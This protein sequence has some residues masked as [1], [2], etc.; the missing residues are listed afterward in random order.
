MIEWQRSGNEDKPKLF[1]RQ[2]TT[3]RALLLLAP[4]DI[5][6]N[7]CFDCSTDEEDQKVVAD[8]LKK[9]IF[10]AITLHFTI[11]RLTAFQMSFDQL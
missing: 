4:V 3:L 9:T 10:Y 1:W 2:L 5:G 7:P 11:S 6:S 8:L